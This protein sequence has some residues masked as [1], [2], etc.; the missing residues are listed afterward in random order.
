LPQPNSFLDLAG[1]WLLDSGIQ[2]PTGG[3][4]RY[5]CSDAGTNRRVS[6]E[7]TGYT[8][9]A[10]TFLHTHTSRSRYLE[11]ARRAGQFLSSAAWSPAWAVFPFEHAEDGDRAPARAYF[12]DSGIIARGLLALWRVTGEPEWLAAAERT[13]DSMARDFGEPSAPHPILLLPEKSPLPREGNWSRHPGCYQLKSALAWH[14]VYEATGNE[15]Y[16]G[17]YEQ[18][19]EYAL[20]T[21]RSFLPGDADPHRV[22][23]RLHAYCYFLEGILPRV[24]RAECAEAVRWG[25]GT[26]AG[27]LREI[28]PGFERSDVCAQLLRARL[29]AHAL[30]VAGLD[31]EAAEEE[32]RRAACYQIRSE[33][34]RIDGGFL[35]GRRNG[36]LVPHVNP[37][38]TSFCLQAL[39]MWRQYLDGSF[40]PARHELI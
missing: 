39:A 2:T 34:R 19:L 13:V 21:H 25:M 27:L 29:Y 3:V 5:Y 23:D 35:F 28:A 11:A 1:Q 8:L 24:D 18:A 14:D 20:D 9:S 12:F 32:A 15:R 16:L 33:D 7:I 36:E 37:V 4:A 38:S 6:T 26:V 22:M 40:Q 10:F 31:R 30:G 17:H